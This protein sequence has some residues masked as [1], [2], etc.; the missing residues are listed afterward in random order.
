MDSPIRLPTLPRVAFLEAPSISNASPQI[1]SHGANLG[2]TPLTDAILAIWDY[3]PELLLT[4]IG[5]PLRC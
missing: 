1:R 4:P 3:L 5:F 2:E